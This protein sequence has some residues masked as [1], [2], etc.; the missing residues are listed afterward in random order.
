MQNTPAQ[1]ASFQAYHGQDIAETA[2]PQSFYGRMKQLFTKVR[3]GFFQGEELIDP[4]AY[5][6][7]GGQIHRPAQVAAILNS[8]RINNRLTFQATVG[9]CFDPF[10]DLK[11][12]YMYRLP[13][14]DKPAGFQ[15]VM[16]DGYAGYVPWEIMPQIP[17][18]EPWE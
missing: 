5:D 8:T 9:M 6:Y 17:Q 13:Q 2:N 7:I 14:D 12:N 10:E 4:P 18:P 1:Y 11:L 15:Y 16:G 3:Q